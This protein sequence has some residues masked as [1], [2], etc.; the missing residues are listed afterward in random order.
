MSAERPRPI[1]WRLLVATGVVAGMALL[2]AAN[3]HLVHVA[4]VSQPDC[5]PHAKLPGEGGSFRAARSAC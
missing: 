1:R 3:A 4:L 5:V 2:V